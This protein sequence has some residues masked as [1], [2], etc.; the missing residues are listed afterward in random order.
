VSPVFKTRLK[1]AVFFYSI[2]YFRS[3]RSIFYESAGL[4]AQHAVYLYE[5]VAGFNLQSSWPIFT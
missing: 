3:S 5:Y 1:F 4:L 2:E